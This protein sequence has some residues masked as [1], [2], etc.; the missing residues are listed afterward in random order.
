M[1]FAFFIDDIIFPGDAPIYVFLC[2]IIS[3]SSFIPPTD[4]F[5]K[6]LLIAFATVNANDVFPTPGG[7]TKHMIGPLSSCVI[8]FTAKNS[9]ILVFTVSNP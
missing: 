9:I 6:F 8:C 2:P 7:P 1:L 4:I 3:A 5:T